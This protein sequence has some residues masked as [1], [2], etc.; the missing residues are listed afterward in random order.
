MFWKGRKST[1]GGGAFITSETV[2]EG[3]RGKRS[4][5]PWGKK[6]SVEW[7][8]EEWG[9]MPGRLHRSRTAEVCGTGSINR[10]G[11]ITIKEG[12][13]KR[14]ARSDSGRK[15]RDQTRMGHRKGEE[16]P[17]GAVCDWVHDLGGRKVKN[18]SNQKNIRGPFQGKLLSCSPKERWEKT[19]LR[20]ETKLKLGPRRASAHQ[21]A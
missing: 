18:C 16:K 4:L 20:K 21:L 1:K 17:S 2:G 11:Q 12:N 10:Q 13:R 5:T 9:E 15:K 14:S 3:L 8:G 7:K 19:D 6:E